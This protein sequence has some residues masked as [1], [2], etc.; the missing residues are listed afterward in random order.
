MAWGGMKIWRRDRMLWAAEYQ[1]ME[2]GKERGKSIC[3]SSRAYKNLGNFGRW[4]HKFL[5]NSSHLPFNFLATHHGQDIQ[6]NSNIQS[7]LPWPVSL[8]HPNSR[9]GNL[10]SAHS[11]YQTLLW[12]PL[13]PV[14]RVWQRCCIKDWARIRLG[15]HFVSPSNIHGPSQLPCTLHTKTTM[16]GFVLLVELFYCHQHK[17]WILHATTDVPLPMRTSRKTTRLHSKLVF[18]LHLHLIS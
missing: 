11:K 6:L 18:I 9:W 12:L 1:F 7:I 14:L 13:S 8:V 15:L 16:G 17:P 2:M 4:G 3:S 5:S 10:W